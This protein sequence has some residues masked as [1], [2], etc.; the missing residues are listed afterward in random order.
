MDAVNRNKALF[1]T[2]AIR[3]IFGI[4]SP[5][6]IPW[7]KNVPYE[8]GEYP[9]VR[10]LSEDSGDTS[11]SEFGTHVF[12]SVSF[13]AGEYNTYNRLTGAVEKVTM[14]L[15]TLPSS[16]IVEF[17]RPSNVTKTDVLGSTGTVKEIYGK[18]DWNIIIRGIALEN[19]NSKG[20]TAQEQIEE[21][22]K[23]DEICDSVPVLGSI[24]QRKGINNLVFENIS[25]QPVVGRWNAIPFQIEA[26]S[27]EPIEFYLT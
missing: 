24:F 27:D 25:I 2:D 20:L 16:C 22:V 15:Y 13:E 12:G 8:A 26:V 18:S 7:G 1:F 21:L 19:R 5:I 23:W 9:D 14:D 10:F 3:H 4:N 11:L 6:Y 17:S